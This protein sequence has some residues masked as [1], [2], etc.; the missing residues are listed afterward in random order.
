MIERRQWSPKWSIAMLG[1]VLVPAVSAIWLVPWFVTQ[2]GPAHVYN[3]QILVASIGSGGVIESL[4][5]WHD[6]FTVRWQPIPNWSGSLL[7]AALVAYLPEW[8]AD[9]IMTSATLV[10]FASAILWLRYR[11]AGAR[12]LPVAALI[13]ALLSLNMAWL[14]GFASFMLGACLFPITLG[15]WWPGRDRLSPARL[16]TLGALL[17]LGYFSHLVSLGLTVLGLVC[18]S[19]TA[20]FAEGEEDRGQKRFSRL[21]RT[22]TSFI[23]V[24]VLGLWY[25]RI[26]THRAPMQPVWT[27]LA[28]L[29]SVRAWIARLEW[30]DPLSLAIRDGLPFT[31]REGL[32]Y[33]V[34][35]PVVWLSVAL[36]FWTCALVKAW[37][38]QPVKRGRQGWLVLAVSLI[39]AGIIGP[40]SMGEAHGDYLPQRIVL[41]GLVAG[42]PIFDVDLSRWW[43]RVT[44]VALSAALL[45]QS[46]IVWDYA[47]YSDR[48]AGQII[49]SRDAIDDGQRV[50]A[51]LTS[52]RSRFRANPL[53]HAVNW[54]GVG[55]GNVIWNNYET[56]HY[57]FPVQFRPGLDRPRPD[58]LEWVS[59]HDDPSETVARVHAW[60]TL[61]AEHA[62]SID[63][64]VC[65]KRDP[66]LDAITARWFDRSESRG[67]VQIFR[68]KPARDE[69]LPG[70]NSTMPM[71]H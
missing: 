61:L 26:A 13:S 25:L 51:V 39:V 41:L 34:C 58:D 22:C 33:V 46:A 68:K 2:D 19:I 64:I 70:P 30:V 15:V 65:W 3:A 36:L 43:G 20:P 66:G 60:E 10:G 12:G 42:V 53:L 52:T 37:W 21:A 63:V 67:D 1:A 18:L 32:G 6:V 55:T 38:Q 35:A 71:A 31:D 11:V 54:L 27:H 8:L 16:A 40:D 28:D 14:F 9:R 5:P 47:L 59:L 62:A 48:T 23:P 50:V 44:I 57:Y 56:L 45:L 29:W 7:L 69:G 4:S 24:I 17:T 49:G